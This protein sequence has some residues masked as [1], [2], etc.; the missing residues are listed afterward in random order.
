MGTNKHYEGLEPS[1]REALEA[2]HALFHAMTRL[3]APEWME[4]DLPTGQLKALVT[5][6]MHEGM[7]VSE[8]ADALHVGKPAASMLVDRLVQ[9]GYVERSE[10]PSDRRRA[11]VVTSPIGADLVE[12]LRKGGG[13]TWMTRWMQRM[14]AED[15]AALT[16]GLRALAAIAKSDTRDESHAEK[17]TSD[18]AS[19]TPSHTPHLAATHEAADIH[20]TR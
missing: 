14:N 10:D 9:Q 17:R 2:Q 5:L 6:G 13:A 20:S 11:I 12:R 1:V 8:V 3:N 18:E 16:Q 7:T 4:L 19:S 15:L